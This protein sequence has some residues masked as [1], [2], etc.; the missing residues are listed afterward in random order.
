ML[1]Q[2]KSILCL[3]LSLCIIIAI[4]IAAQNQSGIPWNNLS[5]LQFDAEFL[6]QGPEASYTSEIKGTGTVLLSGDGP[7]DITLKFLTGL[8]KDASALAINFDYQGENFM[9]GTGS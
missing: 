8:G 4:P 6:H 2:L 7:Q 1:H 5:M 9:C 3:F